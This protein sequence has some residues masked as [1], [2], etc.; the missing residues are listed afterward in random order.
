MKFWKIAAAIIALGVCGS[1]LTAEYFFQQTVVRENVSRDRT[2]KM[3]ETDWSLY[4]PTIRAAKERL[5]ECSK[6][7]VSVTSFDG[8]LLKGTWIPCE[9]S[10]KTAICFHG[11]TSEGMNDYSTIA[12]I[13]RNNQFNLLIV[14]A[15]AHGKSEGSYIGFGCLDHQDAKAWIDYTIERMGEECEIMLHGTSMGGATVL[16][17]SGLELPKQVKGIISD[18]AFTS[19]W[20]VFSSVL[21]RNYHLPEFPVLTIANKITQ[22]RAGYRLDEYNGC[23]AVKKTKIPIAFIHG[24]ADQFVPCSMVYELY[25]ACASE[26]KL[27]V[28]PGAGHVESPYKE[29]ELYEEVIQEWVEKYF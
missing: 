18:C 17:A 7:E 16:M 14:D 29:P 4:I 21:K 28:V 1:Y 23:E 25:E 26:K 27:V 5:R 2:Q 22:Q 9:N 13:Y 8:L 3:S 6:E 12:E 24:E 11:Y 20:E 19:A 10:K 15:R